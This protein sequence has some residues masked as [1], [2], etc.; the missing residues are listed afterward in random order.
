MLQLLNRRVKEIVAI[1][2]SSDPD[3]MKERGLRSSWVPGRML[4]VLMSQ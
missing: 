2:V 3:A 1:D 4:G